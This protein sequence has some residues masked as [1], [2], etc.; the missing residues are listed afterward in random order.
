M[1]CC[2]CSP[3]STANTGASRSGAECAVLVEHGRD[4]TITDELTSCTVDLPAACI[5]HLKKGRKLVRGSTPVDRMVPHSVH[6]HS[7]SSPVI[8]ARAE[9]VSAHRC[10]PVS[11]SDTRHDNRSAMRDVT[12]R[13]K[14]LDADIVAAWSREFEYVDEV[15]PSQGDILASTADA[16]V[17]AANSFGFMDGGL[18]LLYSEHFGWQVEDRVREVI[19]ERFDGELPVGQAIVV[20]TDDADTPWLVCAPT[21]RVPM[22]VASTTHAYLAFR[23]ALRAIRHHNEGPRRPIRTILCPAF[24]TGEGRMPADRCARQMRYAY[25]VCVEGRVLRKGGLA[26]AV[27]NHM[28]LVR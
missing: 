27:E 26:A 21:M 28:E 6:S 7:T 16:I 9:K 4:P 17:S 25:G 12:I 1:T 19:L 13:L 22:N 10:S 23:G 5:V 3:L 24:C 2:S 8:S 11:P 14:A 18:D 15:K 20:P